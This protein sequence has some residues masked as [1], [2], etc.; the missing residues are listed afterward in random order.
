MKISKKV[1]DRQTDGHT[2]GHNLHIY[3]TSHRIKNLQY[4]FGLKNIFIKRQ[5]DDQIFDSQYKIH[6]VK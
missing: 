2:D 3:A 6:N 5:D 4:I 1:D